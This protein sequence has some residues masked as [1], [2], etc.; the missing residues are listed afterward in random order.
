MS[1][2]KEVFQKE[3]QEKPDHMYDIEY[4]EYLY[5]LD[6]QNLMFNLPQNTNNE[7]TN[8]KR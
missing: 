6:L 5:L 2:M 4:A 7:Q 3:V 1:K 8:D